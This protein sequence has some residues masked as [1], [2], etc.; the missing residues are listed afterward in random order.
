MSRGTET[1]YITVR[2]RSKRLGWEISQY[3]TC[4]PNSIGPWVNRYSALKLPEEMQR[5]LAALDMVAL[6]D[7]VPGV[8]IRWQGYRAWYYLY[9]LDPWCPFEDLLA[10]GLLTPIKEK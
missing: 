4:Q 1:H 7:A 6:G 5:R 10:T 3:Y 9:E 8:G 2:R